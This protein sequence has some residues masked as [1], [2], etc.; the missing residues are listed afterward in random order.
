MVIFP[1]KLLIMK[2][3]FMFLVAPDPHFA[4]IM[5]LKELQLM[6]KLNLQRKLAS[7]CRIIFMLMTFLSL[8]MMKIKP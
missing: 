7:S 8:Q 3:V 4:V 6:E 1:E 5:L 2:C